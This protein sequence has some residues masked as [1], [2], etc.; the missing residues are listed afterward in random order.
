MAGPARVASVVA[1][2]VAAHLVGGLWLLLGTPASRAAW[3]WT[4][5]VYAGGSSAA[6]SYMSPGASDGPE[7][8]GGS[9][10][11]C[12][13]ATSPCEDANAALPSDLACAGG[14][15]DAGND[16]CFMLHRAYGTTPAALS[17]VAGTP[18]DGTSACAAADVVKVFGSASGLSTLVSWTLLAEAQIDNS[19]HPASASACQAKCAEDAQCAYFTYNDQGASGGA[20]DGMFGGLC[21]LQKGLSCTGEQHSHHQGAIAGPAMCPT[22]TAE[23]LSTNGAP[24]AAAV[25]ASVLL[26][27]GA[28]AL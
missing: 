13:C 5:T 8:S 20:Y 16:G 1:G 7:C 4:C 28:L 12:S 24:G 17:G 3:G 22:T 18:A 10:L 27:A 6:T 23:P 14:G 15:P 19:T 9:K 2:A 25:S 26:A 21:F 11:T